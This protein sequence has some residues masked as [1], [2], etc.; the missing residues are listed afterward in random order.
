MGKELVVITGAS[1]GIGEALARTFS[2]EGHPL[3]LLARRKERLDALKLPNAMCEKLDVTDREAFQ[4]VVSK[5][6][7]KFGPVDLMIN[8][9]GLML[10]GRAGEQDPKEWEQM[11]DVNIHGVMNGTHAVLHEMMKRKGGTIVN[12]SSIAGIKAFPQHAAYCATKYAVR[13]FSESLREEVSPLNVRVIVISPGVVNTELL[14]HTTSEKIIGDYKDWAEKSNME[15]I[16]PQEIADSIHFAYKMPQRVCVR[17]IVLA[18]TSQG[19]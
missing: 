17:E 12:I 6:E 18:P 3:L 10:L 8:N 16:E 5:A 19:P 9:A 15:M 4:Q 14:G 2:K 7:E 11:T 1:S 13:G